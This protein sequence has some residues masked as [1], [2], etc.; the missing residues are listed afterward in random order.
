MDVN[1][2]SRP[3]RSEPA[4]LDPWTASS[5]ADLPDSWADPDA[6]RPRLRRRLRRYGLGF[7]CL[8]LGLAIASL[9]TISFVL[10][11]LAGPGGHMALRQMFPHWE[12]IEETAVVWSTLI[13][14]CLIWGHW[15]DRA[16]LRRSGLLLM[17]CLVDLV[18]WSLDHAADLGLSEGKF[19]HDWFRRSLGSALG[20][21][22]YALIAGLAADLA[23][24]LGESR[25]GEFGRAARS[26]ATTG[27]MVWSLYFFSRTN[28]D[29]PFWPLR[30]VAWNRSTLMLMLGLAVLGA[31]NLMQITVLSLIAS[32]SCGQKLREMAREDRDP[33]VFTLPPEAGRFEADFEPPGPKAKGR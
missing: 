33:E 21:S 4:G 19:G 12:L 11:I 1:R 13:G 22:E 8:G 6:E 24:H 27:A 17:M 15:P 3:G 2:S 30:E 31:I 18:L 20:W 32:R 29:S 28:W 9:S 5:S 7:S 14:A 23:T 25:A 26:L 16:W 10:L